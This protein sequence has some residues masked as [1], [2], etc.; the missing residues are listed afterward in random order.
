MKQLRIENFGPIKN[1]CIDISDFSVFIGPQA[2]GKSTIAK[3]IYFF[4][5]LKEDLLKYIY[6]C[7]EADG[8]VSDLEENLKL[9]IRQKFVGFWGDI[10]QVESFLLFFSY[11]KDREI[12]LSSQNGYVTAAFSQLFIKDLSVIF[13]N[14]RYV[15]EMQELT[16]STNNLLRETKKRAFYKEVENKIVTLFA[17]DKVAIYIPVGR[18][19]LA[20]LSDSLQHLIIGKSSDANT[21]LDYPLKE[22]IEK[23]ANLKTVYTKSLE[24]II[25]DKEKLSL[26]NIKLDK[27]SLSEAQA[28][29]ARILKGEYR[30]GKDGEKLYI[31][32]NDS[33][34]K[35]SFA[36]SGQQE[37][38][39]IL[40]LLFNL[41]LNNTKS[42]I[43]IE[44]PEAHLYPVAQ[45]EIVRLIS[46]VAGLN[47]NQVIITTHSPYIVTSVNNLV[48]A[49]QIGRNNKEEVSKIVPPSVWITEDR[50]AA[51]F[52]EKGEIRTIIDEELKL[53]KA[54]EIDH[55]SEIINQEF[56]GLFAL[57]R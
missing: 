20:T 4:M 22:F 33:H 50:L 38:I 40:L 47:N 57:D 32:D 5:S 44:E 17:E 31:A 54:E 13:D 28:I 23:I 2:S 45:K 55:V 12:V 14:Y 24:E 16:E 7:I 51:Y 18:S 1:V 53:I 46:L 27:E 8:L 29:I 15:L 26:T 6:N 9:I 48:Y 56:E 36:S 11:E 41:I 42:L 30:Y 10:R 52:V 21:L 34:V 3:A 49:E 39:W 37:S 19:L 25:E 35:L 43:I